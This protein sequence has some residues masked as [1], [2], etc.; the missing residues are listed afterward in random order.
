MS[1]TN[2]SPAYTALIARVPP[3]V[4]RSEEQNEAYI[5]ALH[6]LEG[7]RGKLSAAKLSLHTC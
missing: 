7:R 2:V 1:T 6:E 3:R 5:T 4:T